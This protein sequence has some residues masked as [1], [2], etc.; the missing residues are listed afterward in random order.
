MKCSYKITNGR[1]ID[2]AAGINAIKDI[3]VR[4][5]RIVDIP[6]GQDVE[7]GEVIDATDCLVVPGLIDFHTHLNRGNSDLGINPDLMTLPNGITSAVD[8]GSTGSANFEGFYKDI[9]CAADITIKSFIHVSAIG[10]M[11]ERCNESPDPE[12]YDPDRIEYMFERYPQQLLGIK[13]RIGQNFSRQFGLEPLLVAKNLAT[14]MN[15]ALCVHAVHPESPY[16]DILKPLTKGDILCHCFQAK[17]SYSILDENGKISAVARDARS[18][19]VIFDAASGRANYNFGVARSAI[20][21][22]FFPDIISTD[23]VTYSMYTRKVFSLPWVLSAYLALGMPLHEALRAVTQN[24]AK[25]MGMDGQ[26]GT[27]ASGALADIAILKIHHQPMA[28]NDPFGNNIF[29]NQL[30]VPMATFKAGRCA[31]MRIEFAFQ[32]A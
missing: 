20:Q 28:F 16:D 22:G 1:V 14:R 15:T 8:A 21:D 31:F 17:G 12:H 5:S 2:P 6:A 7:I 13:V 9:V 29:G 4:N 32:P 30:L 26:I 25:L 24:P 23:V 27:L 19:G 3:Y 18:R 10:V 11:A